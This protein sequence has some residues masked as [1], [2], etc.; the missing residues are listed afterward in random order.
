MYQAT[1][2]FAVVLKGP[3]SPAPGTGICVCGLLLAD[4]S[5]GQ[6]ETRQLLLLGGS[7]RLLFLKGE[8]IGLVFIAEFLE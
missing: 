3:G 8:S 2:P 7:T 5:S 4:Q 1:S 6:G